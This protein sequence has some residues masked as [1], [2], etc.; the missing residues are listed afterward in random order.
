[1]GVGSEGMSTRVKEGRAWRIGD[2]AAVSWIQDGTSSGLAI[3]SAIPPVFD[4]YLTLEQVGTGAA[5][6]RWTEDKQNRQD[7]AILELLREHTAHQ[8]WWLGFLDYAEQAEIVF[9]DAPRVNLYADWRYVLIEAGPEQAA[10]W[11]ERHRRNG[12]LPALM[13][14]TDRSW[15]YSNL[16]DDDWACVGGSQRLVEAFLAHPDLRDRA[17]EVDLSVEDATPPGHTAR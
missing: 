2:Q 7:Q 4:A 15:L 16:W 6:E 11:R 10:A 8:R 3:T 1:M 9:A 5:A 12:P 13:F 17:L 14:P